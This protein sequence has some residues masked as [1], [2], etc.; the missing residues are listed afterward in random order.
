MTLQQHVAPARRPA[1]D[2]ATAIRLAETEYRRFAG[3]LE[4]LTPEDWT[5]PTDCPGWDVRAVAG[6]C[7][8]MAEM[9]ASVRQT[10]HQ[11]RGAKRR[12]GE[13]IDALTALQ[14]EE[15]AHLSPAEVVRRYARVGP[16]AAASR[17]RTPA[18]VR[19]RP[20]P[21][22][23]PV[24]SGTEPWTFGYLLDVILT[25]D[26]WMHRVDISRATGRQMEL[27]PEHDGAIVA[28]VVAEWGERCGEAFALQLTG[29]AGGSWPGSGA[30][31]SVDAVEFCRALSGR[32]T[33]EATR[34]VSV[35]F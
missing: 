21:D 34:G 35:P 26:P 20:M 25:R 30:P 28:D 29:P 13:M 11:M 6:H 10:L 2:H 12:G 27:T 24:G 31:V 18:L 19:N 17:R 15:Q 3:M 33:V 5:K 32:V 4:S 23:Q 16:K 8:G 1:L 9:A 22:P 14:V 7:L